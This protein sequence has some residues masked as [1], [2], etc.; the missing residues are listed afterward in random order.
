MFTEFRCG[1]SPL[2][3]ILER[4]A[5]KSAFPSETAPLTSIAPS[6]TPA[7]ATSTSAS[8]K[9]SEGARLGIAVAIVTAVFVLVYIIFLARRKKL[10]KFV[11]L[12]KLG[13]LARLSVPRRGGKSEKRFLWDNNINN[14][15]VGSIS[16][17]QLRTWRVF[18]SMYGEQGIVLRE[19]MMLVSA[20]YFPVA[21][22][23]RYQH[24]SYDGERSAAN[25]FSSDAFF[26]ATLKEASS[27]ND[28]VALEKELKAHGILAVRNK[29]QLCFD[30]YWL[31]DCRSWYTFSKDT[32]S[33]VDYA[34]FSKD[35]LAIYSQMPHRDVHPIAERYRELFYNH[36]HV[37]LM[38]IFDTVGTVNFDTVTEALFFR[39]GLQVLSHR[40]QD[41]DYQILYYL[42]GRVMETSPE[43]WPLGDEQYQM[44]DT[45]DVSSRA[46]VHLAELRMVMYH[47]ERSQGHRYAV[48]QSL[49]D[50]EEFLRTT[51]HARNP[52]NH[53]ASG[54]IGYVLAELMNAAE[55]LQK[56]DTFERISRVTGIWRDKAMKS[57]SSIE[58][59]ALCCV[60]VRLRAL[61]ELYRLPEK[62]YLSCGYYLARAGHLTVAEIFI[63]MGVQYY[64]RWLPQVPMWRYRLELCGVKMR[65]GQWEETARW[66][67]SEWKCFDTTKNDGSRGP[68]EKKKS[69]AFGEY[70]LNHAFLL[71]DCYIATNRVSDALN[72][73]SGALLPVTSMRDSFIRSIR[74]ALEV[75]KLSLQLQLKDMNNACKTA[76]EISRDLQDPVPLAAGPQTSLWTVQEIL[77]CVD[78]LIS[79]NDHEAAYFV[80]YNLTG[81]TNGQVS[82]QRAQNFE[83]S[84][85]DDLKDYVHQRWTEIN[86]E[87]ELRRSNNALDSLNLASTSL[88]IVSTSVDPTLDLAESNQ[89]A[90]TTLKRYAQVPAVSPNSSK[91]RRNAEKVQLSLDDAT[92]FPR[93][94]PVQHG[95]STT[96]DI[97]HPYPR[98]RGV[99]VLRHGKTRIGQFSRARAEL[100][101]RRRNLRNLTM[102]A[103]LRKPPQTDPSE[104]GNQRH[105]PRELSES[106]V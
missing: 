34:E 17:S 102:L 99:D 91:S 100:T 77:A 31:T 72:T 89:V 6:S 94:L 1:F 46:T 19:L 65:L 23:C 83:A 92:D 33:S 3:Q 60:L 53:R 61:D 74:V 80:L 86:S 56:R 10:G 38:K 21:D 52:L 79:A 63:S 57:R 67:S 51:V 97:A 20:L 8:A 66:L 90:S 85:P 58:M 82:D 7:I 70:R 30:Q 25:P 49:R 87:V 27:E 24:W 45:E 39:V 76:V 59:A 26:L 98:A 13:K 41:G 106:C 40:Y 55:A 73:I 75:R 5:L 103:K 2:T 48:Q 11:K 9:P 47:H 81:R 96:E 104:P 36:A 37:A 50:T 88:D 14:T 105:E 35:L 69:G 78:E 18:L 44:T 54:M 28:L 15:E 12:G 29:D 68:F 42:Q 71:A 62:H 101:Q 64:E 43:I 93:S 32:D 95:E 84:L 22:C 4:S 16:E